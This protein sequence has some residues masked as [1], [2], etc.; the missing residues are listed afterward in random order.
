MCVV[1]AVAAPHAAVSRL[2]SSQFKRAPPRQQQHTNGRTAVSVHTSQISSIVSRATAVGSSWQIRWSKASLFSPIIHSCT[3]AYMSSIAADLSRPVVMRTV[4]T[5]AIAACT[6]ANNTS[7]VKGQENKSRDFREC[8][9]LR[10]SARWPFVSRR[11]HVSNAPT[12]QMQGL[13]RKG[14]A[15]APRRSCPPLPNFETCRSSAASARPAPHPLRLLWNRHTHAQV[16]F[17][18]WRQQPAWRCTL[19]RSIGCLI[20]SAQPW[21]YSCCEKSWAAS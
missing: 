4:Y 7:H 21:R 15:H 1:P 13:A 2:Q 12:C 19:N 8:E 3:P 6:T 16:L 20:A 18:A 5:V 10:G 17:V 11:R 14:Q 9:I